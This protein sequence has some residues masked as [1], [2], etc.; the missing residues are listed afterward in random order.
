MIASIKYSSKYW[1]S[2]N[3]FSTHTVS[4][5][6]INII[7]INPPIEV[8]NKNNLYKD[9]VYQTFSFVHIDD[10]TFEHKSDEE[11]IRKLLDIHNIIT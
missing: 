6:V 1:E 11:Q 7:E 9:D 5:Y 2:I 8:L 3:T 4:V 10:L